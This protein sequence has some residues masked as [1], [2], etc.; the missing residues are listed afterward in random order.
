MAGFL[1][2]ASPAESEAV[3]HLAEVQGLSFD[4]VM[5]QALRWYQMMVFRLRA[6]ETVS[7][8]G[9]AKRAAEFAGTPVPAVVTALKKGDPVFYEFEG[10]LFEAIFLRPVEGWAELQFILDDSTAIVRPS[11]VRPREVQA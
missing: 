10:M 2:E 8:S 3:Q 4:G 6:G 1:F 5:R 9:D 7:F 11:R